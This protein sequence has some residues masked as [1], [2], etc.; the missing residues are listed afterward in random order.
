MYK[1]KNHPAIF[2]QR[3]ML[4]LEKCQNSQIAANEAGSLEVPGKSQVG[5]DGNAMFCFQKN[6]FH[7]LDKSISLLNFQAKLMVVAEK[8]ILK[9]LFKSKG[10][11]SAVLFPDVI[12][13]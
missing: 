1:Q 8:R 10:I 5:K 12:Q 11:N 3:T 2:K 6:T 9:V 4:R 7:N 13:S